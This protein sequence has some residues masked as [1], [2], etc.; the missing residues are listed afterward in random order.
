M[1]SV[2]V[3]IVSPSICHEVMTGRD[4]MILVFLMLSFKPAFSLSSFTLHKHF[5]TQGTKIVSLFWLVSKFGKTEE[6]WRG[7]DVPGYTGER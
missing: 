7:W 3:S 5:V 1:K 4:A 2:A 6:P